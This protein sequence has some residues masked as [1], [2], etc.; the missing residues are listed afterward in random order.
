M[1]DPGNREPDDEPPEDRTGRWWQTQPSPAERIAR[2]ETNVE[3]LSREANGLR[4]TVEEL[5]EERREAGRELMATIERNQDKMSL[6]L[7]AISERLRVIEQER[8]EQSRNRRRMIGFAGTI[9]VV[10]GIGWNVASAIGPWIMRLF[11]RSAP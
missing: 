6:K 9:S 4:K 2:C 7:E 1:V 10:V 8:S 5:R 11:E 3:Y